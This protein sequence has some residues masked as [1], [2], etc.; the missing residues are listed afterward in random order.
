M[1]SL[2]QFTPLELALDCDIADRG[3]MIVIGFGQRSFRFLAPAVLC[4]TTFGVN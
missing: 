3:G 4:G 2:C 1:T